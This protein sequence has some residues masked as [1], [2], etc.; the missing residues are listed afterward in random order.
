[1]LRFRA[2]S[3]LWVLFTWIALVSMACSRL[4]LPLFTGGTPTPEA[5]SPTLYEP[6]D[7]PP[8][9]LEFGPR[10]GQEVSPDKAVITLRF[11]QPMDRASVE[12]A[13]Q[14]TPAVEG[15]ATWVD[16]QTVQFRPKAAAEATR[17]RVL[18][19]TD[20][21]SK[22]GTPLASELAFAFSTLGP[23]QATSLTPE[24][25]A[26]D[27]RVDT[28]IMI[29]FNRP[30]VPLNCA[31]KI[32]GQA[33]EC[34]I[35]PLTITPLIN[36][37]AT[38]V[39][40]SLYR[41]DPKP[42]WN[43][44]ETYKVRLQQDAV[45][46]TDGAKLEA[47]YDWQFSTALP[48]I[49]SIAPER[50]STDL[51]LDAGVQVTFNT[52]MDSSAT[53]GAFTVISEKGE[54]L[55]GT[56]SWEDEGAKL[57][58]TPTQTMA[59]GTQYIVSVGEGAKALTGALLENPTQ[60]EFITVPSPAI[61]E[62]V[63]EDGERSV[64][65]YQPV[66]IAL[67][68]AI[69][70]ATILS[71]VSL[72]PE[73]DKEDLYTYWDG[74]VFNLSWDKEPRT[75]YCVAVTPG[76][77]DLYGNQME[78]GAESC[79][80]TGDLQ[81]ILAPATGLDMITLD[82]AEVPRL[83]MITRNMSRAAFSLAEM[84]ESD[85]VSRQEYGNSLRDWNETFDGELNE[86][87]IAPV[88]L[89][90]QEATLPTGYYRLTWDSSEME[91]WWRKAMQIAVVDRHV[92]LKLASE[93]ALVWVTDLRSGEPITGT[94][95]RLLDE[96]ATLLAAGTTN[97]DGIARVRLGPL[98]SLWDRVIAVVGTPGK[99]GF[100]VAMS[101]W[102]IDTS[103][104]SFGLSADYGT[105][106]PYQLYLYSDRSI[107]RPGQTIYFKGVLREIDDPRYTLPGTLQGVDVTLRD[108]N[109]DPVYSTTLALSELGSF[110]GAFEL[111]SQAKVGYYTLQ[112]QVPGVERT[113]ELPLTVA[114]YRKPEFEVSVVAEQPDLLQ[115]QELRALV[116]ATYYFGGP[117]S[118]APFHWMVTAQ[119]Y[120]FSPADLTR[121]WGT[122]VRDWW[123]PE[124][125]AQGDGRTDGEGRFLLELPAELQ[126]MGA[127][128]TL[129]SQNWEIEVTLTDESGF[130]VSGRGS[131]TVHAASFYLGLQPREWVVPA[132]RKATVDISALDW[133]SE[134]VKGQKIAVTLAQR[135]WYQIPS[136]E[137]FAPVTWGYTDTV[138]S[139]LN[140]TTDAKGAAEAAVTPPEGGAYVV[141][142]EAKDAEGF[143]VRGETDLWVSGPEGAAWQMA[144]GRVTPVADAKLY[145][146]GDTAMI[147]LPTPFSGPFQVLMT[148][149]RGSI[150][151]VRRFV[152]E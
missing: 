115:G 129:G 88:D 138:I 87:Q 80:T 51:L 67:A 10:L 9:I 89:T 97:A 150:L 1:M 58:F 118:D 104:W 92:T 63:P 37:Q 113:W 91:S 117:V 38:W 3:R 90:R 102:N 22:A 69:D 121:S 143:A 2:R 130:P 56:I 71:H 48:R 30:V 147:Q 73:I 45:T 125:I 82:A 145:R 50:G 29:T 25:G 8:T 84:T 66:Q 31:G 36:G 54:P 111:F 46:S 55:P 107:Y 32:A 105:F 21:R 14:V 95:V 75:R 110:E 131:A 27:L 124:V 106:Y 11:N 86:A 119:P 146:P 20:A 19:S 136:S 137:P 77:S 7:L 28:P 35:L 81:S 60:W 13:L 78:E 116:E 18:L 123:E 141:I 44:G 127:E 100:G 42:G 40:T 120:T 99:K 126:A 61:A 57:V 41:F 134:P 72:T 112:A 5:V 114:A 133:G 6:E 135:D 65:L 17:Y 34:P 39:N 43:A 93:E 15:S 85:F 64:E 132:G 122:G 49:L 108:T 149:E 94:E 47:A 109:W 79:F 148:V 144:E 83:Y 33:A 26:E 74:R 59:L 140:V 53:A 152:S 151:E 139:T 103:P 24:D 4:P 76:I 70:E 98:S 62:I 68:G 23:L 12:S 101:D 128:K 142:A 52:P 96:K 16:D